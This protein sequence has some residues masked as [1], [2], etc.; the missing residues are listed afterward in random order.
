MF[1]SWNHGYWV[2]RSSLLFEGYKTANKSSKDL[3]KTFNLNHCENV[4]V[5]NFTGSKKTVYAFK[6]RIYSHGATKE[7]LF[8]AESERDRDG[9]VE[10]IVD[11]CDLSPGVCVCAC[12]YVCGICMYMCMHVH[13][14]CVLREWCVHVCVCLWCVC[15]HAGECV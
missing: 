8:N 1:L 12:M 2:L 14:L 5:C 6:L 4:N 13:V 11:L 3:T 7:Y 15:A 10:M 9:W